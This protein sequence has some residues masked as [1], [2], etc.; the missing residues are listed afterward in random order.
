MTVGLLVDAVSAM[1]SLDG[2]PS[3]EHGASMP[4]WAA[5]YAQRTVTLDGRPIILLDPEQLLY[6]EKMH[7]YRADFS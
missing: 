6:A 7:R 5:S 3:E 4:A 2:L 1:R